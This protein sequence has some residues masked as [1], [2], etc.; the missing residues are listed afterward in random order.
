METAFREPEKWDPVWI[1]FTVLKA[2]LKFHPELKDLLSPEEC[3]LAS[4]RKL[5]DF[6]E[7]RSDHADPLAETGALLRDI[8]DK[9]RFLANQKNIAK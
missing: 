3:D 4:R 1:G 9:I 6:M 8:Q 2:M 7:E 5:W